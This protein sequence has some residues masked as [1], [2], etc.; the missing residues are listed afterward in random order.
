[1]V[2]ENFELVRGDPP[3]IVPVARPFLKWAG[4]KTKLLPE[5]L[6]HVPERF[7]TYF[8]PF[9]GG[10]ALFFALAQRR[11]KMP[12]VLSDS[13]GR[14]INCYSM[15][16]HELR[17][18]TQYLRGYQS[19][20]KKEPASYYNIREAF[21]V[22]TINP[23]VDAAR[24]IFLNKTCFNGLWRVNASG[25]FNTPMGKFKT[26][27][28]ILDEEN[29]MAVQAALDIVVLKACDFAVVHPHRGD[30]WY[31]DPPYWPVGGYAD[32]TGYTR[33]GFGERD[34][35]RLR[36]YALELKKRGVRVLLSNADL[37][38]V[39]KLYKKGFEMRRVEAPRAINS[40]GS[41]RGKV[42]ELLI[43]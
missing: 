21:N 7:V 22:A 4:G 1:M 34:Q 26:P 10:G 37:E 14:L 31:A 19:R 6:K 25:E 32:F 13:N 20:Y 30:F 33:E 12:A 15:V 8:E 9:L 39:R 29:L 28:V 24:V 17:A 27:P 41:K 3:Q 11:P 18:V 5:L 35:E 16:R 40:K 23:I 2:I 43:W 42:G 38:P 36:D